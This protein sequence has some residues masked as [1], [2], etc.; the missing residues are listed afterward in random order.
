M[1]EFDVYKYL[2]EKVR[3]L[4]KKAKMSQKE[5]AKKANV[6]QPQLSKF[7]N[8]GGELRSAASINSLLECLGYQLDFSEKKTSLTSA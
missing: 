1:S 3:E 6:T 8:T 4:R 2:G 5:L 7:E